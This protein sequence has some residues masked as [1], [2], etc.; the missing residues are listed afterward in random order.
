MFEK[1]PLIEENILEHVCT[2]EKGFAITSTI[3]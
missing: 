1:A 2:D 3:I